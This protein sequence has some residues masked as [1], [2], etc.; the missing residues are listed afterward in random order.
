MNKIWIPV[1]GLAGAGLAAL[2]LLLP[3]RPAPT[4]TREISAPPA[5]AAA[6]PAA[7]PSVRAA[8]GT[9][10]SHASKGSADFADTVDAAHLDRS[11]S[12]RA[13]EAWTQEDAAAALAW[14]ARVTDAAQRQQAQEIICLTLA[15][16]D[17]RRAVQTAIDTGLCDTDAGLL[18]NLTAQWASSDFSAAHTWVRE[19]DASDW[20]DD[21]VA[22]VAFAGSQSD[23]AA[24]AQLVVGE[25]APGPK[26]NEAAISVLHQWALR[27]L[28]A[29]SAWA[30]AFPE[31][32]LRTR[33]LAEIEGIRL[34]RQTAA[35]Q[36]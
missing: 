20:R 34:S 7:I 1:V 19:Q 30:N 3:H 13:L 5:S 6:K 9:L 29:A 22:R 15:Q 16:R 18:E 24:A 12:H 25:M 4:T 11:E 17:P 31:G 23:P 32:N 8:S 2:A 36:P 26:Q 28:A 35:E 27:D 21:L 14:A 33:A 10:A